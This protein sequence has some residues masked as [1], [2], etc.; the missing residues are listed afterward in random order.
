MKPTA[1]GHARS[2]EHR[3]GVDNNGTYMSVHKEQ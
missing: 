2:T 3:L 1:G